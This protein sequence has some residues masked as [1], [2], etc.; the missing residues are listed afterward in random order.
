MSFTYLGG[1]ITQTGTDKMTVP[2]LGERVVPID[3]LVKSV[4]ET[5]KENEMKDDDILTAT[6]VKERLEALNAAIRERESTT[7]KWM[8]EIA[9]RVAGALIEAFGDDLSA[10]Q[11]E[12]LLA[13][14]DGNES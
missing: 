13:I 6:E 8:D 10:D 2:E 12:Q 1:V 11:L 4:T 9:A 7:D 3:N 14:R 5:L